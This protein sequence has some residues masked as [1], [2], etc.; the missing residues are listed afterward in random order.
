[1]TRNNVSACQERLQTS[2]ISY[3]HD[4]KYSKRVGSD[5]RSEESSST[6]SSW[7][8]LYGQLFHISS[9]QI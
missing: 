8:L 9:H 1:M 7:K 4:K 2:T 3:G 6:T 5:L